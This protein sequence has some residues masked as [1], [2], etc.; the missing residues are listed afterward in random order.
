M[1]SMN[2]GPR[3]ISLIE[4]RQVSASRR[5]AAKDLHDL[6]ALTQW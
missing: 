1:L 4:D 6:R 2:I 5:L 3:L